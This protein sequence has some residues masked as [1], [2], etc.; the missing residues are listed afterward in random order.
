MSDGGRFRYW[1]EL[2][3]V[4]RTGHCSSSVSLELKEYVRDGVGEALRNLF[5]EGESTTASPYTSSAWDLIAKNAVLRSG[6]RGFL[7]S[8]R[9][10]ALKAA[11]VA[12]ER[13][14]ANLS[15]RRRA[16]PIRWRALE[17]QSLA[18]F[19]FKV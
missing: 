17:N 15:R 13:H 14:P 3:V 10:K 8:S 9:T 2:T 18:C 7:G 19:E 11:S 5:R 16:Q 4:E 6:A 12:R 1:T